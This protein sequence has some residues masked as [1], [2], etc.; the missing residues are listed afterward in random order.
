M[1][2]VEAELRAQSHERSHR[3]MG[4]NLR[5]LERLA[6]WKQ[7][8]LQILGRLLA[9]LARIVRSPM[10]QMPVQRRDVAPPNLILELI[11]KKELM[12]GLMLV[13]AQVLKEEAV[14]V[15]LILRLILKR[16]LGVRLRRLEDCG[17][18]PW[19]QEPRRY[20]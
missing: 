16:M 20:G 12:I 11:P 3:L 14:V 8:I 1:E 6:Y 19:R 13:L 17:R 4:K 9:G 5:P 18:Y 7:K 2:V 10:L 15:V